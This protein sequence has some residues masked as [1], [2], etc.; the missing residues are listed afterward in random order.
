LPKL[1]SD[2]FDR[3]TLWE[4]I[5]NGIK[6]STAKCGGDLFSFV[7]LMLEFINADSG[8]A[9]SNQDLCY[10]IEAME[11]RPI[12]WVD[13]MMNL[14]AKKHF[15]IIVKARSKWNQEKGN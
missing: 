3:K 7:N 14:M 11:L 12:E 15:I 2:D 1:F 4:R 10:F 6:S 13:G 5:G 9:A 8:K